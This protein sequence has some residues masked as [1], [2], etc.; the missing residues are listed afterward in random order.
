MCARVARPYG[1][2]VKSPKREDPV[3]SPRTL[4][5][6]ACFVAALA[7]P[8]AASATWQ[9]G[10]TPTPIRAENGPA[11]PAVTPAAVHT[12]SVD[13]GGS[14][15]TLPIVFASV[16]LAVALSGAAYMSVRLRA[17]PRRS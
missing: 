1:G 16:A 12:V 2:S 13:N 3:R 7:L 5:L 14:S 6:I 9:Q 10:E 4:I 15:N 17:L 11:V 8:A